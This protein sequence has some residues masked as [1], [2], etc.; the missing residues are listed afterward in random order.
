MSAN[1]Y[2]KFKKSACWSIIIETIINWLKDIRHFTIIDFLF[3][4]L[5]SGDILKYVY[6]HSWFCLSSYY[7]FFLISW[8]I[9][10]EGGRKHP[11]YLI[12]PKRMEGLLRTPCQTSCFCVTESCLF[13]SFSRITIQLIKIWVGNFH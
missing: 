9:R 10:K 4:G 8:M 11:L 2:E 7:F 13:F 6:L 1:S 5:L 3:L 12:V